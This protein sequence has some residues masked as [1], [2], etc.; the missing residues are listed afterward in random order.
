MK[1]S[2]FH[3]C[4]LKMEV[5]HYEEKKVFYIG[6]IIQVLSCM[7]LATHYLYVVNANKQVAWIAKLQLCQNNS[8]STTM[9]L[10]YNCTNDVILTSLI[11]IYSLKSNTWH[12]EK[13]RTWKSFCFWDID[14][15]HPL[16]L[17]KVVQDVTCGII[18]NFHMAYLI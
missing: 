17:L 18:E 10:H 12:Y 7:T 6:L 8:F 4:T 9:Q 11:V 5:K 3:I 16:W 15:H 14:F 13:V 2:S 1:G